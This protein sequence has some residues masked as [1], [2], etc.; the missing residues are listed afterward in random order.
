MGE[1]IALLI[2]ALGITQRKFAENIGVTPAFVNDVIN[3]GKSFS[4]ETIVKISFK[5]R[6]DINWLLTGEGEMFIPSAEEIYKKADET[7]EMIGVLQKRE[8]MK[9]FLRLL[10]NLT[11]DEWKRLREMARLL[12]HK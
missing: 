2:Q 3:R 7:R 6:V 9:D 1:R 8:G 10:M 4:Q 11:D 5:F 12:F